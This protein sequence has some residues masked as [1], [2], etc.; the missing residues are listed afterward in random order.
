[1]SLLHS[2]SEALQSGLAIADVG[3][4]DIMDVPSESFCTLQY[5]AR[6][7]DDWLPND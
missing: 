7:V 1:M 2:F 5:S 6:C 3:N 4:L